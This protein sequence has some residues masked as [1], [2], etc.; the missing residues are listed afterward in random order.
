M[1]LPGERSRALTE[2]PPLLMG[3]VTRQFAG[4]TWVTPLGAPI[5]GYELSI[6]LKAIVAPWRLSVAVTTFKEPGAPCL[7]AVG[8]SH[9]IKGHAYLKGGMWE[10]ISLDP[11]IEWMRLNPPW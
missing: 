2:V 1:K 4:L 7:V 3:I 8:D 5:E 6:Q 11:L 9:S 10:E